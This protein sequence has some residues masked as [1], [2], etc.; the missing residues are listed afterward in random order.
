[1]NETRSWW[2]SPRLWLIVIVLFAAAVRLPNIAWDQNHFFHP[3]ERAVA[4]SVQRLSFRPLQ[5][6]PQFL[7]LW[8]VADLFDED[9]Q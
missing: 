7:Q 2:A 6:I 8:L 3:D 9:H 4:F 1:M 5:W